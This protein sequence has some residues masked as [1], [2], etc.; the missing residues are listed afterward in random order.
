M[1]LVSLPNFRRICFIAWILNV[2]V[3]L[4]G[5]LKFEGILPP[6]LDLPLSACV[7]AALCFNVLQVVLASPFTEPS[8]FLG[9]V[10]RF[11]GYLY[12]LVMYFGLY[13]LLGIWQPRSGV[14][15]F[16]FIFIFLLG[17]LLS[18]VHLRCAGEDTYRPVFPGGV[19]SR[20][21]PWLARCLLALFLAFE[22]VLGWP[23]RVV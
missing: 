1:R 10:L 14:A 3:I 19:L 11:L 6:V 8:R 7:A 20:A 17:L 4:M 23:G 16:S 22:F 21:L 5:P 13:M 12:L 15:L 9:K 2:G 18:I